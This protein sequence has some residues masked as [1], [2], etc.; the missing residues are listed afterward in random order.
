MGL[1][2]ANNES[3][4]VIPPGLPK[5]KV[6]TMAETLG[7]QAIQTYISGSILIGPYICLNSNGAIL[8]SITLDEEISLIKSAA[9]DLNIHV[10]RGKETAMGNLIAANDHCAVLSPDIQASERRAISDTLGV[11][12][13]PMSIAGRRHV[14]SICLLTN[15]GGLIHIEASED[16][17][18]LIEECSK[19]RVAR[20][21]VNNGNVFVR[22]GVLANTKGALIGRKT[23]GPELMNISTALSL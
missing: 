14:G 11:E 13:I 8:P 12:A 7:S 15:R 20:A 4:L 10:Y 5:R 2:A 3:L 22:S 18:R 21:T 17:V 6:E 16:E 19:V 1:F 23:I 9:P